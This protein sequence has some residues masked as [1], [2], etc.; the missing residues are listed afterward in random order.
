MPYTALSR[1]LVDQARI[2]AMPL[3]TGGLSRYQ[4]LFFKIILTQLRVRRAHTDSF[5]AVASHHRTIKAAQFK[6]STAGAL[7]RF[8]F[9]LLKFE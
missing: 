9:H 3:A 8:I 7:A 6:A 2:I 1:Q 5:I 4:G